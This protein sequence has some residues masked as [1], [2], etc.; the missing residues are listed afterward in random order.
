M[1]EPLRKPMARFISQKLLGTT[2]EAVSLSSHMPVETLSRLRIGEAEFLSS[3]IDDV[4][5][6][7]RCK[8]QDIFPDEYSKTNSNTT[9]SNAIPGQPRVWNPAQQPAL[10]VKQAFSALL[11]AI[12][13]QIKLYCRQIKVIPP[14][15]EPIPS[16]IKVI[17]SCN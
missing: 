12:L 5:N 11:S 16:E 7:F 3:T 2:L 14:R 9:G 1:R 4:R 15:I 17:P 8:L 10:S 6:G 13:T